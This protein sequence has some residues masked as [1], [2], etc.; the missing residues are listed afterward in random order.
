M[1]L[2][3][4]KSNWQRGRGHISAR[5][6]ALFANYHYYYSSTVETLPPTPPE[7]T[8]PRPDTTDPQPS[9]NGPTPQPGT[10]DPMPP[11][12]GTAPASPTVGTEPR[13]PGLGSGAIAAIVVILLMLVAVLVAGIAIGLILLARRRSHY[14]EP[15]VTQ[16]AFGNVAYFNDLVQCFARH[17]SSYYSV[18]ALVQC[19]AV[20]GC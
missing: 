19:I 5:A 17:S 7:I 20:I 14:K 16:D 6:S 1:I 11:L 13:T 4:L 12:N 8:P 3:Y 15:P 18:I 10:T 2:W 9:T